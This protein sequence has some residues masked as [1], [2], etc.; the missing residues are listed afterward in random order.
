[1]KKRR[2]ISVSYR[3]SIY[4]LLCWTPSSPAVCCICWK[5]R[6]KQQ[7]KCFALSQPFSKR[8]SLLVIKKHG[9]T[10]FYVTFLYFVQYYSSK[11]EACDTYVKYDIYIIITYTST[12][13]RFST[14][15][16]SKSSIKQSMKSFVCF[17]NICNIFFN[18]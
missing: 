11:I 17:V 13:A 7:I 14:I 1:M 6:N 10:S 9:N 12:H 2:N 18:E 3:S 8:S 15:I 4:N 16:S 5:K